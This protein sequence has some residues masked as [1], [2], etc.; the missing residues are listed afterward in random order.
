MNFKQ[1]VV[2]VLSVV[3]IVLTVMATRE[4]TISSI[5]LCLL[6]GIAVITSCVGQVKGTESVWKVPM[7]AITASYFILY[8]FSQYHGYARNNEI[9]LTFEIPIGILLSIPSLIC[10][11]TN[12]TQHG[13][14]KVGRALLLL[15][16]MIG[17]STAWFSRS[18][19]VFDTSEPHQVTATVEELKI[20]T[21]YA[22]VDYKMRVSYIDE[23]GVLQ[24]TSL[25]ISYGRYTSMQEGDDVLLLVG[26]GY[27]KKKHYMIID[28]PDQPSL[29]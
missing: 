1:V 23:Q 19:V 25:P 2:Y 10:L 20:R 21:N 17:F 11:L 6:P 15:V 22:G 28:E 24:K 4:R 8:D 18:N 27:W 12:G 16:L 9:T 13:I 3:M 26:E 29:H 7:V 5:A 14:R